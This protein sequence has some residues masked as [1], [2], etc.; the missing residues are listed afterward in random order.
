[1]PY[2]EKSRAFFYTFS[3]KFRE[4][5]KLPY[6]LLL[7]SVTLLNSCNEV[8][9]KNNQH[10]IETVSI[11]SL[12]PPDCIPTDF[13]TSM[14]TKIIYTRVNNS[15]KLSWGDDNYTRSHDSLFSCQLDKYGNRWDWIPKYVSETKNYLVFTNVISTSSGGNSAPIEFS[16]MI[17]PKKISDSIYE[18]E[19][20][21]DIHNNYIIYLPGWT[22]DSLAILNI[23]T[24]KKQ[25]C[26]LNPKP[27]PFAKS[28][29]FIITKTGISK[30][31]LNVE[32]E[33]LDANDSVVLRKNSFKLKI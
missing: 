16:A 31:G 5:M 11:D 4:Q 26:I 12:L 30:N 25:I 6:V 24:K 22:A 9:T 15:V 32:Y 14:G 33:S 8:P 27:V 29:T 17:F 23:E 2:T 19:M 3:S 1:M 18:K 20:Y 10:K 28:P 21:I 7:L 13:I